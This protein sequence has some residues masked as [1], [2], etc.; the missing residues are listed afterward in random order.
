M[1]IL[2]GMWTHDL[3]RLRSL[4]LLLVFQLQ[5]LSQTPLIC[6]D[7]WWS[8]LD[9]N[10]PISLPVIVQNIPQ[11]DKDGEGDDDDD[12]D[13]DDVG[14]RWMI[15]MNVVMMW[16]KMIRGHKAS[17]PG[18]GVK[19]WA[20]GWCCLAVRLVMTARPMRAQ[21]W[22]RDLNRPIRARGGKWAFAGCAQCASSAVCRIGTNTYLHNSRNT[23]KEISCSWYITLL[24][25][26][27]TF[28]SDKNL[29]IFNWIYS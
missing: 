6:N 10:Q 3:L 26:Q 27:S 13:D 25:Y 29:M 5:I 19:Q 2:G 14:Q 11:D 7:G 20:A 18:V 8:K 17:W 15:M 9:L 21:D 24:N 16:G 12:D 23:H 28:D 1:H 4:Q 22:P